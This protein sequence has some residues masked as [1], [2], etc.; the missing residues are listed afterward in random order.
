MNHSSVNYTDICCTG[1]FDADSE[2]LWTDSK[3]IINRILPLGSKL[4]NNI[5]SANPDEKIN[6]DFIAAG[7]NYRAI[8][9]KIDYI[10]EPET[11]MD[12]LEKEIGYPMFIKPANL[13]SSIGIS[14]CKN[15]DE[16]EVGIEV[17]IKYD[18]RI[19]GPV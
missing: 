15:R 8:F 7:L 1:L 13:G 19:F 17:A 4:K 12:R 16:L 11:L 3:S 9:E 14:K 10:L 2:L 18:R 5:V 6:F